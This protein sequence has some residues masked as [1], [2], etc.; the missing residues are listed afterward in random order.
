MAV[1]AVA[2]ALSSATERE[3]SSWEDAAEREGRRYDIEDEYVRAGLEGR[4]YEANPTRRTR[5][6][7]LLICGTTGLFAVLAAI[8][9]FPHVEVSPGWAVALCAAMLAL[10]ATCGI[11]LWR[12]TRFR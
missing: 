6:D 11:A 8:A 1:G 3:H 10:L 2:I 4:A 9:K 7:W 12:A 5:I